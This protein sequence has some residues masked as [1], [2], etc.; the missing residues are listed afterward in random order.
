[1]TDDAKLFSEKADWNPDADT[2]IVRMDEPPRKDFDCGRAE[3]NDFFLN[4]A[5]RYQSLRVAVTYLLFYKGEQCGFVS[6]TTDEIP[7]YPF[8]RPEGLH[9]SRLPAL[10][11]AQMGVHKAF[12]GKGFGRSLVDFTIL[13]G[14]KLS[15]HI[16]CRYITL[17]A[18]NDLVKWYGMRDGEEFFVVNK[19]D[20]KL[21]KQELE[22]RIAKAKAA[23]KEPPS[24]ELAVSMRFDLQNI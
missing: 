5:E 14:L 19:F 7:L 17:D 8:E 10:K 21:R 11:L 23:G 2:A 18:K 13:N 3:Q 1:M 20:N 6:L 15:R 24:A 4:Y 9:I 12:A 22:E 16:G